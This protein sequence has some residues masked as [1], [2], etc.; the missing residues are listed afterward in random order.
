MAEH[1]CLASSIKMKV[2]FCHPHSPKGKGTYENTNFLIGDM[3][4]GETDF[5]KL[6]QRSITKIARLLN[7]RPRQNACDEYSQEE[8][9]LIMR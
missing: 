5:R 2:Y 9:R 4:D 1:K 8:I 7:E 3:L 6:S